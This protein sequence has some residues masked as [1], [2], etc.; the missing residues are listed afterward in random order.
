MADRT[1][2]EQNIIRKAVGVMQNAA[3][4][5]H[6]ILHAATLAYINDGVFDM[7]VAYAEGIEDT[8]E[9]LE[10]LLDSINDWAYH[11]NLPNIY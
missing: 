8:N 5:S 1:V 6:F 11:V 4:D 2:E 9:L 7:L 10:D 3:V